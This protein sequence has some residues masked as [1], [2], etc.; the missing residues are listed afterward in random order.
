MNSFYDSLR[1]IIPNRCN[2]VAP[3][4][5]KLYRNAKALHKKRENCFSSPSVVVIKKRVELCAAKTSRRLSSSTDVNKKHSFDAIKALQIRNKTNDLFLVRFAT[6][7][8]FAVL[9]NQF[10]SISKA[11]RSNKQKIQTTSFDD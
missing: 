7:S 3:Q 8:S 5:L 6:L 10:L 9:S 2:N 11:F 4:M 1:I